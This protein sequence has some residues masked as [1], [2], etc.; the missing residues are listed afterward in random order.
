[1]NE[2][3]DTLTELA[4]L[5]IEADILGGALAPGSRLGITE[6]AARY[7]VGATPLREA[8][9]RL[10]AR[11]LVNATGKRGFRVQ[12]ISRQDLADIIRVRSL[13]EPEALRLSMAA[14]DGAW[15]GAIVAA[16]HRLKH[17]IAENRKGFGEGEPAFDALHKQFHTTLLSACGSARLI[18][19]CANLYDEAY[20]YRR[21][22]M[23]TFKNPADFVKSHESLAEAAISRQAERA[24]ALVQAHIASTL[25]LVYPEPPK[26]NS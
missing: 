7:R 13:L 18:A 25:T 19:A 6:T 26:Q 23:S 21:L 4:A 12:S 15:E 1:V 20:R 14:G 5:R 11:G 10:A 3:T 24:Q 17:Y 8:L 2:A 9:A 16:L 22:M